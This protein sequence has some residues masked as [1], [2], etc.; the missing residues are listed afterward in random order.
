MLQILAA[1]AL[2]LAGLTSVAL[3]QET[4]PPEVAG[5]RG[6]APLAD[7]SDSPRMP[8]IEDGAMRR[9]RNYPE[10]PPTIPHHIDGYQVDRNA[11]QCLSCHARARTGESGAPMVSITHFMDREGQFLATVSPRR[12]FCNQCHVPQVDAR[13]PVENDFVDIDSLINPTGRQ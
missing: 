2:I 9:V 7:N 13:P 11:N 12:Y 4:R 8:R 10:Q 1:A 5:L 3:T 6:T